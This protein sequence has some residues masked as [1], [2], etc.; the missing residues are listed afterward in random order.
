M[1]RG[2][3][4]SVVRASTGPEFNSSIS[5]NSL[6]DSKAGHYSGSPIREVACLRLSRCNIS[7]RQAMSFSCRPRPALCMAMVML[8]FTGALEAQPPAA[9]VSTRTGEIEQ[10]RAQKAATLKP[11]EVSKAER[12]LRDIR[13]RKLLERISSGYNGLRVKLGNMVTG[14]GFALGPEYLREDL[15][16]GNLTARASA[17]ASTRRYLKFESEAS[18]P[19]LWNDRISLSAVASYRN[20]GSLNYY[21]PGPDSSKAFRSNYRLEDTAVD[22]IGAFQP[23]KFLKVG[24][25]VGNLWVNVGPGTDSRFSST[26]QFYSEAKIP[27]IQRQTNFLRTGVFAQIDYRDYPGGAKSGGNYIFQYS[28]YDDRQLHQY[29]FRRMDAEIQ[30]FIPFFNKTRRI[31]LRAKGTFTESDGGQ[32]I[33]FYLQP[34][35]GGS[36]DLRGYRFF[37]F[38]DRNR[39]V[40]NA[41]YQ[42]EIF[43]GLDGAVFFDAGKVMPRRSLLKFSDLETSAGFG[44][45]FNVR[46]ATFLR[47]DVGFSHEG[48]QVWFKFNDTFVQRRFGTSTGQP[49][50]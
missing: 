14:G 50:Y 44:L 39:V 28:W 16:G 13:D 35:L 41:E 3:R 37:R 5:S 23:S 7:V 25:S 21:G 46:N 27:G 24:G 4:S 15:F 30:Q 31:A 33:P 1:P 45:R 11:E 47:V 36:D 6:L 20:Y 34:I 9:P 18:L 42:W 10:A 29:G 26:D 12:V 8:A 22:G 40:Y 32:Q 2:L 43:S 19:H 49:T 17:Q 38:S 48:F